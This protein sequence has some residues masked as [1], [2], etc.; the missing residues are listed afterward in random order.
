[1]DAPALK[2]ADVGVAMGKAGTDVAR[3]ASEIILTGDNFNNIVDAIEEGRLAFKNVKRVIAFL[4]TTNVSEAV[5][6]IAA[7]ALGFP[8][9]LLAAQILWLNMV[10]ATPAVM[11]LSLEP[12]HSGMMRDRPRSLRQCFIT[13]EVKHLMAVIVSVMMCGTLI[14][15]SWKL[16]TD[17][18]EA[19]RTVVFTAFVL[20][21]MFNALNCRSLGEPLSRVGF[22]TNRYFVVGLAA[23]MSLQLLAI[24]HP[25]FQAMFRTVPLGPLDWVAILLVTPWIVFAGE[26]QKR[27]MAIFK[28][29]HKSRET[30]A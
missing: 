10:T 5:V 7:M 8:L 18:L 2:R 14:L 13:T 29:G 17:T 30:A 16:L 15:F 25:V 20:F 1:N 21:E 22:W 4:F 27:V 12:K 11:S 28:A 24:Y 26:M 19:A 6:L 3:E 23:T 9:P